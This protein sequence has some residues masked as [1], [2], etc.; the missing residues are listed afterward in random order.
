MG[1]PHGVLKLLVDGGAIAAGMTAAGCWSRS[2]SGRLPTTLL[3]ADGVV[4]RDDGLRLL[5]VLA[6][7]AKWNSHA[8]WAA[9]VGVVL[10]AWG[11]SLS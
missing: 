5:E 4:E 2:A 9:V 1:D 6:R 10:Q 3:G 11:F 7:Q 8:A